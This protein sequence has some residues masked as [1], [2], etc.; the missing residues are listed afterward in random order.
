MGKKAPPTT[1]NHET[2]DAGSRKRKQPDPKP[3]ARKRRP[4]STDDAAAA[5]APV[6]DLL[7]GL[8]VLVLGMGAARLPQ[9][10][11][12]APSRHAVL[13]W[14]QADWYGSRARTLV[15]GAEGRKLGK[16]LRKIV[17]E[18]GAQWVETMEA[19]QGAAGDRSRRKPGRGLLLCDVEDACRASVCACAVGF[20]PLHY[21]WL[22]H[23]V[24]WG[25]LPDWRQYVVVPDFRVAGPALPGPPAALEGAAAAAEELEVVNVSARHA[26]AGEV[27]ATAPRRPPASVPLPSLKASAERML[28]G[29]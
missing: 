4:A 22:L 27:Q 10:R 19:V 8:H 20:V 28:S 9:P 12:R 6:S 14:R 21:S 17:L 11:T 7:T 25:V 2:P 13:P 1:P 3:A 26:D 18:H 24:V 16:A 15:H 23:A 5:P 29:M